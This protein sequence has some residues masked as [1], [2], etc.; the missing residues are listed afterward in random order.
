MTPG[1]RRGQVR[2]AAARATRTSRRSS[3]SP[4][5]TCR[6]SPGVGPKT[7]AKWIGQYD[8]LQGI[9]D[10]ADQVPGKAGESLRDNLDQ[11]RLNR[12]LNALLDGPRAA[13]RPRGPRGAAVGPARAAR[14]PRGAA[15]SA[16]SATACSPCSPTRR[17]GTGDGRRGR[18]STSRSSAP[19]SSPAGSRARAGRPLGVDVRGSGSPAGGDAWGIALADPDGQAAVVRPRRRSSP[20]TRRRWRRGSRTRQRPRS[21]TRR[22]RPGTRWPAAGCR[23]RASCSTPSSRRTCASRTGA[24]YDLTDLAIGY[25]HRELG[26]DEASTGGQGALDLELDGTDEGRRAAVR[27]AAVRDLADVLE[28]RARRP[29]RHR[30]CW[31]NLELPLVGRAGAHGAHRHRDRLGLPV[32]PGEV[33]STGR[34]R[35]RPPRRTR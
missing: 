27:A 21:C 3:A 2:R 12:Q 32:G 20:P 34:C 4:A 28:R 31:T 14:D 9:L 33:A 23:S 29:R 15:S 10:A 35:T 11:V 17:R 25:L 6:A 1:R 5:T 24:A 13:A 26:A 7:A 16:P 8:G 22:R 30:A 18:S 19:A